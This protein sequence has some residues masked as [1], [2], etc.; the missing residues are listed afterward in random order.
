MAPASNL[1]E[2][3]NCPR[4]RDEM[5]S[6]IGRINGLQISRLGGGM[7]SMASKRQPPLYLGI[8]VQELINLNNM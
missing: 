1:P 2:T 8:F 5:M 6:H 3:A 4:V 7:E